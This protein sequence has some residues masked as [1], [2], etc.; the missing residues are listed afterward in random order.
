MPA[1]VCALAGGATATAG[2][3]GPAKV[4]GRTAGAGSGAT[5]LGSGPAT[6]GRD[7]TNPAPSRPICCRAIHQPAGASLWPNHRAASFP[8]SCWVCAYTTRSV[9]RWPSRYQRQTATAYRLK[10]ASCRFGF[11]GR[12]SARA[13]TAF[14]KEDGAAQAQACRE[15]LR[16]LSGAHVQWWNGIANVL[17]RWP[18]QG[19]LLASR[20]SERL[21]HATHS[22]WPV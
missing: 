14:P 19:L 7:G 11:S 16:G 10:C 3:S 18:A 22:A 9:P 20:R 2:G 15:A 1:V 6:T 5:S 17:L 12:P 13:C 4:G 21:R 8:A